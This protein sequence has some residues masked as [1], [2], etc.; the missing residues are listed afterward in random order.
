MDPFLSIIIGLVTTFVF[1]FAVGP[2][3]RT[4]RDSMPL[5]P[6][7]DE[8][9][10]KW[11]ELTT[12]PKCDKSGAYLGHVE[13]ILFFA[14]IWSGFGMVVA[15]WLAFKVA[16]KWEVWRN[17]IAVP[18][19]LKDVDEFHYLVARRRW[20]SQRLMTFL[21]GTGANILIAFAGVAVGRYGYSVIKALVY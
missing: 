6:P 7:S 9:Q 14:G 19:T 21:I 4:V 12:D 16:S 11:Q 20:G 10:K 8:L 13:R 2:L 15:G 1:G 18:S 3:V 17:L 5:P